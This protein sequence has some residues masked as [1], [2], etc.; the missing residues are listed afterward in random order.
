MEVQ[1]RGVSLVLAFDDTNMG[2]QQ[3]PKDRDS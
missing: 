1:L 3:H 2:E